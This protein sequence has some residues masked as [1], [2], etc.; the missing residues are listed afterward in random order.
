MTLYDLVRQTVS[1][2]G[3]GAAT[4]SSPV[5]SYLTFSA[6]GV[7]NNSLITYG[8][9]DGA[10]REVGYGV[11]NSAFGTVTRNLI[12]STTGSLLNLSGSAQ[13]FIDAIS[14]SVKRN[15]STITSVVGGT[16]NAVATDGV[17]LINLSTPAVVTVQLLA[18]A[19]HL[20]SIKVKDKAGN[21]S[22]YNITILPH[23]GELI[24]GQSQYVISADNG[25]IELNI[26]PSGG[27]Y[28]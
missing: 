9:L 13:I 16:Y 7:P 25:S 12:S 24:D 22:T 26:D 15:V 1:S 11:Y 17:L 21:A 10:S 14:V 2:T 23:S 20:N 3:T 18:S 27:W 28:L 8:I 4:L 6:A 5:A 19:S